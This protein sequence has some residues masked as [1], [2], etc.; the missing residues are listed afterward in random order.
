MK[1]GGWDSYITLEVSAR[2]WG[3]NDYDHIHAAR[4]SHESLSNAFRAAGV[5]RD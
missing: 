1:E 2:V 4:Y 5:L 3:L